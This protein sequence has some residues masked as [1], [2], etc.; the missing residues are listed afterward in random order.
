MLQ[1]QG[2]KTKVING[3]GS[4]GIFTA[5]GGIN[6]GISERERERGRERPPL[7]FADLPIAGY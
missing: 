6:H 2:S 5:S 1:Y 3:S 4:Q 7:S